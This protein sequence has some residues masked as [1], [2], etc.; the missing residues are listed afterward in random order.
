MRQHLP[1]PTPSGRLGHH[2]VAAA[3]ASFTDN[4]FRGVIAG[5][6]LVMAEAAHGAGTGAALLAGTTDVIYAG[7]AFLLP[8]VLC[9]PL[10]GALGDRFPKHLL[11]R[12]VRLIDL[13]VVAIGVWGAHVGTTDRETA[14]VLLLVCLGLLGVAAAVYSSVKYA[15]LGELVGPERLA[16]AN[17]A[18]QAVST[19]AI[20]LGLG[21]AAVADP[22]VI[23]ALGLPLGPA[24]MVGII[25]GGA[26]LIGIWAAFR[27]P[28]VPAQA[29]GTPLAWWRWIGVV[30]DLRHGTA[31]PA[32]GLAGFWALGLSAQ[33]LIAPAAF[34]AFG[35]GL[36]G[37]S[38]YGLC[39]AGGIVAGALLAPRLGHRAW[40]IG[41]PALGALAAGVLLLGAGL[42][43]AAALADAAWAGTSGRFVMGALLTC[44]GVG[45]G[46]WEIPLQVIIQERADPGTRARVLA[47][48][49]VLGCM[50]MVGAGF[51]CLGLIAAGLDAT[52]V[53]LVVAGLT[54]IAALVL[55]GVYRHAVVGTMARLGACVLWRIEVVGAEHLPRSGG[56]VIVANHP[57]YAD[58]LVL[59]AALPRH[60]RFLV[61]QRFV[62]MPVLGW[63]LRWSGAIRVASDR[64]GRALV[65]AL[66]EAAICARAGDAVGILPEGKVYRGGTVDTFKPGIERVAR[67][68]GVPVVPV[69]I[70]G[71]WGG[72][73]SLAPVKR[74]RD[75]LPLPTRRLVVRIGGPLPPE[76]SARQLREAVVALGN[77][78]AEATAAADRRT[79]G[80]CALRALAARPFATAVMDIRGS[81]P[82]WRLIGAAR[83]CLPH[84]GLAPDERRVGVLLPPGQAGTLINL[85]LALD[86]RTAVNLNHTAGAEQVARM[87]A[88]AGIRTV[89]SATAYLERVAP[90]D[91][92]VAENG[93][94]R[95]TPPGRTVLID[96]VLPR[97]PK[98]LVLWRA[99]TGVL[100]PASWLD[101]A[102][103]DD[104]AAIVFSSGSTSDPK[105]V[106]LS[107]RQ[108][109]AN[110][111]AASQFCLEARPGRDALLTPL[112]LFH[113]FGL[114]AGLWL[115]LTMRVRIIA[116]GDPTDAVVIGRLAADGQA[117]CGIST[118]TFVRGWMR[119]IQPE[120][121]RWMR[122]MV[123]GAERCPA[124]LRADFRV[125]YGIDLC[126]GY[127]C[128]ELGPVVGTNLPDVQAAGLTEVRLRQ[129]TVGRPM[130][131]IA[132]L[133]MHP[134]TGA[135]LP[136]G[137]EGLLIVRSASRMAGYLDR[138]DL[139][140]AACVHGGYNTGD[141]GRVDD[142][143]FVTITGRLARFAKIGGE[144]VH[145]DHVEAAVAAAARAAA[146]PVTADPPPEIAVAA[147]PD[148]SRGE[149]LVVL[150]TGLVVDWR[151]VL[152]ETP[153]LPPLWRPR[154]QDVHAVPAIPQLGTGKRDLG[155]LKRLA[156]TVAA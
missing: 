136:P 47:A 96:E 9:A 22:A 25:G 114:S 95:Y 107:H 80:A 115:P 90:A 128:T 100:L 29:P 156:A 82:A 87:C 89:L 132:V 54:V 104:V 105:G 143:G 119:R 4:L 58:G 8:M 150:H 3:C 61:Y 147:V 146:G 88:L 48:A 23:A 1:I 31:A 108:L 71:L 27:V 30:R 76:T 36:V 5:L 40:P 15:V 57:S 39:L 139:T 98:A 148:A 73:C 153:G 63:L 77:A 46:L 83:T 125:R 75:L 106:L 12:W 6:L 133:T 24:G 33:T 72:W 56:V 131:G 28:V 79:L 45:A 38:A 19:A 32:A 62:D 151:A 68:A 52:Q 137:E 53:L 92:P 123:V 26:S 60:V 91:A 55:V 86:G 66:N 13:P 18:M 51:A 140:A 149:R 37:Q 109:V 35:L 121:F 122:R 130:D 64:P 85:A 129:G 7:L 99:L 16:G 20:L 34:F 154:A 44:C 145:L 141:I 111:T 142:D 78:T 69:H 49:N 2:L 113:S 117:T 134:E 43:A 50:A 59:A 70:Q 14:V 81:L 103:P 155:G 135:L 84:L 41:L 126:E 138:P 10:A 97:M 127:G 116:H 101:R 21:S 120:Q 42:L 65:T 11:M 74:W 94:R 144:M 124:E 67:A 17:A 118:A 93:K 112:P 110:T 152:A 102:R